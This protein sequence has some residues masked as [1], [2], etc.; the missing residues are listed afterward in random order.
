MVLSQLLHSQTKKKKEVKGCC[1]YLA[2]SCF[3]FALWVEIFTHE[4]TC[5][6]KARTHRMR[7]VCPLIKQVEALRFRG[8]PRVQVHREPLAVLCIIMREYR[9]GKAECA[10]IKHSHRQA[11]AL[12]GPADG[13]V[14]LMAE[15]LMFLFWCTS[16]AN[17]DFKPW[18][19]RT[20]RWG[21]IERCRHK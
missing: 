15:I 1:F 6:V 4:P 3:M 19:S 17:R 2:S 9:P 16:K 14:L 12:Y 7:E 5:T 18:V 20:E 11:Q 10:G 21:G 8:W 13:I